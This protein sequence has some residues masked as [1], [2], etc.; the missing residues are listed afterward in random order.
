MSRRHGHRLERRWLAEVLV[1]RGWVEATLG[2]FGVEGGL[3]YWWPSAVDVQALD[4]LGNDAEQVTQL[5][6]RADPSGE[7]AFFHLCLA[8]QR[9]GDGDVLGREALLARLDEIEAYRLGH[10][11][12]TTGHG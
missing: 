1:P 12:R 9:E 4:H 6:V 8:G 2:D 10:S 11:Q 3:W 5:G 7:V